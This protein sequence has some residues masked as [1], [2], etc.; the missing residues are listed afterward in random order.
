[1]LIV[2]TKSPVIWCSCH[3]WSHLTTFCYIYQHPTC[4]GLFYN[5]SSAYDV[6]CKCLVKWKLLTYSFLGLGEYKKINN[7][8]L[9]SETVEKWNDWFHLK[10]MNDGRVAEFDHPHVLLQ[11]EAG[12]FHQ[13]ASHAGYSLMKQLTTLAKK[14]YNERREVKPSGTYELCETT[15][16]W[17]ILA[18]RS[19]SRWPTENKCMQQLQLG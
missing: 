5:W 7:C 9:L 1:M 16:L 8:S 14:S 17:P 4:T 19:P 10:V 11:N 12:I 13:M 15:H 2:S 18:L 3:S 6:N